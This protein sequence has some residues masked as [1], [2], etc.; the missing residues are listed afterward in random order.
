MIVKSLSRRSGGTAQLVKYI[1]RYVTKEKQQKESKEKHSREKPFIIRHNLC[2][3]SMNGYIRAFNEIEA[4]REHKRANAIG[5]YHHILSF[6]SKDKEHI[7]DAMLKELAVKFIQLR[8]QDNVYIGTKH[9]DKEHIHLHLA[10]T[11]VDLG[12]RSA[13]ISRARFQEL[14]LELDRYQKEHYPELVNSLPDHGKKSRENTKEAIRE[15][16]KTHRT[17]EKVVLSEVLETAF[18]QSGS[19]EQ[20]LSELGEKGYT[21]YYRSGILTGI[22]TEGNRKFRLA[23]LGYPVE[24][25]HALNLAKERGEKQL[26]ELKALRESKSSQRTADR[27]AAMNESQETISN[28]IGPETSEAKDDQYYAEQNKE[29]APNWDERDSEI[30]IEEQERESAD[31]DDRDSSDDDDG[32]SR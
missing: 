20:F 4:L 17:T 8:G 28:G 24:K 15:N 13:R 29:N 19:L 14:K 7:S 26:A 3:R 18:A 10:M 11:A 6:S 32:R 27:L 21:P 25:L 31:R 5:V 22:T 2:A 30:D 23:R 1:L 16:A 9:T 12:G